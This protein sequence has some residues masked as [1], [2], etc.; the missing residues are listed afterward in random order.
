MNRIMIKIG[1]MSCQ[2]CVKAVDAALRGVPGVQSVRVEL[3]NERAILDTDEKQFDL[4]AAEQAISDQ[5]YDFLG[6]AQ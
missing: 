1:G 6:I 4:K 3:A 2:H 5:G